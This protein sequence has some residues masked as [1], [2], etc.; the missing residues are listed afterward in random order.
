VPRRTI[1]TARTEIA[2]AISAP[3]A[4][5]HQ[6]VESLER[7]IIDAK[8][9]VTENGTIIAARIHQ[10]TETLAPQ[11]LQGIDLDGPSHSLRQKLSAC[12]WQ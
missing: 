5:D 11:E 10:D 2:S 6:K 9:S 12:W 8:I 4:E 3:T 1:G 7:N